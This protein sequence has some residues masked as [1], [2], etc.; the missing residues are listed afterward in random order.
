[1]KRKRKELDMGNRYSE[2]REVL[3]DIR[4]AILSLIPL[5]AKVTRIEFEGPE[6]AIYTENPAP[7]LEDNELVRKLA[8][9]IK[10][11]IVIRTD[12]KVRMERQEAEKIIRE[13]VP[14][15]AEITK[16]TFDDV[17]GEVI[18]EAK[19]PGFVIG[20]GGT[21]LKRILIETLWRPHIIRTPPIKSKTVEWM[22]GLLYYESERR[23]RF[24]HETGKRIHRSVIFKENYVR[25]IALGGF[26]EVGRS[27]ILVQT[28]ESNVLLDCGIKPTGG[29]RDE[30]PYFNVPEFNVDDIDA[31]IITH[32][33]LDH[34][35]SLP[36]LFKF[37]YEGPVYTTLPT[38]DLM[39]LLLKDY[40]DVALKEGKRIPYTMREVKEALLHTITLE[41]G[42]VTDIA[43]DVRLTFHYAGHILG[44]A[45]AHLHIGNGLCN[46]VYTGD[47]KFGKTRLLESASHVFPRLEILIMESTYGGKDDI[48]PKRDTTEQQFISIIKET[49][50]K[51]GKVLIPVLAV[52]RGQEIMLVLEESIRQGI[53]P[54]VPIYIDG[55]ISEATAL[56]TA[57]PDHLA[58]GVREMIYKEQNPFV[59]EF[60]QQVTDQN[61][62]IEIIE[63]GPSIIMAT[64]GML[65]GGP[66]VEYLKHLAEDPKNT[67]IFVSYQIEGTLGRR[68]LEM[69]KASSQE[70]IIPIMNRSGKTDYLNVKMRIESIEGFSGHSDRRQLLGFIR[71]IRPRPEKVVLC[72][73]ERN[74]VEDL[75]STIYRLFKIPVVTPE[76]LEAVRAK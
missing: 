13:I 41:Y 43:P 38:R 54:P 71:N 9:T 4:E 60:F 56:H 75:A 42:E 49:L 5:D 53:L 63:G 25:V 73:G 70:I 17:T 47:F 45:I 67:L 14:K 27:A 10:K 59:Q 58:R 11:R 21:T 3:K 6:I 55:M 32:A 8:K 39:A 69:K 7:I 35:G 33:H 19:K 28:K 72:H 76:N 51:G 50:E 34:C 68:L 62:R 18:I 64:S 57:Y 52:G 22:L 30:M 1:M 61:M 29:F 26:K 66:S 74:R 37:G 46:I 40:I 36:Y 31:V 23:Q 2:R 16:I 15:E 44:S 12:P 24:L 20:R 48:M 65:T